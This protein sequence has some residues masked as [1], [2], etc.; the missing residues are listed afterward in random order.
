[1]ADIVLDVSSVKAFEPI[2]GG[3][4]WGVASISNDESGT[5]YPTGGI[6]VAVS[7]FPNGYISGDATYGERGAGLTT[8]Y[9]VI[10]EPIWDGYVVVYDYTAEKFVLYEQD[11]GGGLAEVADDDTPSLS[12]ALRVMYIG[13]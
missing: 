3:I 7:R 9:K 10:H 4:R 1:M 6:P 5:T 2:K 8:L 13:A 11:A 12:S